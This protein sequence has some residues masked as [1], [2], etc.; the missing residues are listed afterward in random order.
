[1]ED[2]SIVTEALTDRLEQ[3]NLRIDRLVNQLSMNESDSER[4]YELQIPTASSDELRSAL[5]MSDSI[6]L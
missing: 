1:M 2:A 6:T 3:A 4:E 5:K